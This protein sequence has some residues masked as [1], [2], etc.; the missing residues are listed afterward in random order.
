MYGT[1]L[2]WFSIILTTLSTYFTQPPYNFS[3]SGVGLLN[4]PPFIGGVIA[5]VLSTSNDWIILQLAKRNNGVFEPEMRLWLALPG[6]LACPGGTLLFGLSMA[7]VR[8][9][10]ACNQ[11]TNIADRKI[12]GYPWIV[13]CIGSAIFSF[14]FGIIGDTSLTYLQDCYTEVSTSST[15]TIFYSNLSWV[16]YWRCPCS[17]GICSQQSGDDDCVR[18][19][20]MD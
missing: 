20:T 5:L 10:L 8:V 12:Q 19:D 2:A 7:K 16:G 13:P 18:L 9:H 15:Q 4:L 11:T 14:G 17:S 6:V 1:S 3:P